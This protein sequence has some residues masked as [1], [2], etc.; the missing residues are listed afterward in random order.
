[1]GEARTKRNQRERL[2][3]SHPHCVFCGGQT[4]ATTIE[5]CP[6]RSLFQYRHWPEGFEFPACDTCNHGTSDYDLLVAMLARLNPIDEQGNT[7][8]KLP[9]LIKNMSMQNPGLIMKMLPS[10]TEARRRNRAFGLQPSVGQT[11][12]EVSPINIPGEI[13]QA[14]CVVASKLAKAIF[15]QETLRPFPNDGCLMLNWFTNVELLRHGKYIVFDL[16]KDLPGVTPVL[17]RGG[18]LLNDQFE[19]KVSVDSE[20]QFFVLQARF[21][22]SFAIVVF[23]STLPGR[24]ESMAEQMREQNKKNGSFVVLQSPSLT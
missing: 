14:V 13:H 10:A 18:K 9:G 20:N 1:M 2:L 15:Y 24:L 4:P 3:K 8:G 5:H 7:D 17:E 6:P 16:L 12:Q 11:Q 19:Y 21:N 23:G 22:I